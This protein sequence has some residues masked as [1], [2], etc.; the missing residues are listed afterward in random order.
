MVCAFYRT[1]IPFFINALGGQ[2]TI[3]WRLGQV[4]FEFVIV[5]GADRNLSALPT[6]S[7]ASKALTTDRN[8]DAVPCFGVSSD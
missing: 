8:S 1:E 7:R 3:E 4:S 2:E 6:R 5:G